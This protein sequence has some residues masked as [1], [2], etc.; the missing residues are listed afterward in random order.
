MYYACSGVSPPA[1][2]DLEALR[3]YRDTVWDSRRALDPRPVLRRLLRGL[4]P[5]TCL[6]RDG[7][8]A[9]SCV[10]VRGPT[11]GP[12]S[13]RCARSAV[14]GESRPAGGN[15]GARR[16]R[17]LQRLPGHHGPPTESQGR[18]ARFSGRAGARGRGDR[19]SDRCGPRPVSG[20]ECGCGG[21]V[22]A[23]DLTRRATTATPARLPRAIRR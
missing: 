23:P 19:R 12:P 14:H 4:Q 3:A 10:H 1:A 15:R 2:A 21:E 5:H 6:S 16:L 18:D 8:A 11:H 7:N 20:V 9:L 22:P 17:L 13:S